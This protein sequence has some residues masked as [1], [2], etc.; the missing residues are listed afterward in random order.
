MQV[1]SLV[2]KVIIKISAKMKSIY[3]LKSLINRVHLDFKYI[4]INKSFFGEK[5][6]M[7]I[8]YK[9]LVSNQK[10]ITKKKFANSLI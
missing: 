8:K 7:V 4:S 1:L 2:L 5:K 6:Y 10:N 3:Y 9:N